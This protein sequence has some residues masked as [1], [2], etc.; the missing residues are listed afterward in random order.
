MRARARALCVHTRCPPPPAR[1]APRL[2]TPKQK[3]VRR[4][5]ARTQ[6]RRASAPRPFRFSCVS[7]TPCGQ[8]VPPNL[9]VARTGA[10]NG[11]VR[12][13]HAAHTPRVLC[14]PPAACRPAVTPNAPSSEVVCACSMP[15]AQGWCSY[16]AC[17]LCSPLSA[18]HPIPARALPQLPPPL[19]A[20]GVW[21]RAAAG[22]AHP[23]LHPWA[24][25]HRAQRRGPPGGVHR[26]QRALGAS[27]CPRFRRSKG[28][29]RPSVAPPRRPLLPPA[30]LTVPPPPRAC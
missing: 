8:D 29:R 14:R 10:C 30:R 24:A 3:R 12:A 20:D 15:L 27:S 13:V 5:F 25:V 18:A 26:A 19:P 6:P 23:L 11:G 7:S 16:T 22:R 4:P 21:H 2:H 1:L 28:W 9:R 17:T